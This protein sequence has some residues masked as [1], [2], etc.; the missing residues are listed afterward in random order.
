MSHLMSADENN[1]T[2]TRPPTG[3][4]LR[5]LLPYFR[6]HTASL[7]AAAL[8]VIIVT[9]VH[10]SRPLILRAIIDVAIPQSDMGY[11]I[12][13]ALLFVGCLAIG[14]AVRYGQV[15]VLAR[16]GARIIAGIKTE[17]FTHIVRHGMRFFD[18]HKVGTLLT[19]SESDVDQLKALFTNSTAQVF[20]SLI[21]LF[22]V[23]G[24]VVY[25]Q[26]WFG[27]WVA[28]AVPP[29][30]VALYYYMGYIRGLYRQIREK[31]SEI[32]G[33]IAEYIQGVPLIQLYN[34]EA[35]VRDRLVEYNRAKYA[36]ER[37]TMIIDYVLFWPTFN[38]IT[39]TLVVIGVFWYGSNQIAAGKMS[40]G[41]LVMFIELLR[42][43]F[44]PIREL[45]MVIAQIQTSLAASGRIFEILDTPTDVIDS[46]AEA[47][48]PR[49][50]RELT[51]DN[52]SFSYNKDVVLHD[53][54][55]AAKR[56]Q[57]VAIVGA[58]GSGK[59]TCV[60]LL[61][62]FYDPT[63][64]AVR[65]DGEDIRSYRLEDWRSRLALVLQEVYLF[66]GTIMDNLK[67]FSPEISDATVIA[68]AEAIGAHEF[69]M[70]RPQG[71]Q[72]EL[73]E[74]GANLS[75]GERQLLSYTR[76]MVRNPDLLIL[77]EATSA[78][79]VITERALQQSMQLLMRG[80]TAIII[81]HRLSTIRNADLILVFAD[82][83]IVESGTHAE[84]IDRPEGVYQ[85]LSAIQAIS[86]ERAAADVSAVLGAG[87]AP[88]GSR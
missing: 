87:V 76:A 71:Y 36:F 74:R 45:M 7:A 49:L 52:V 4:L 28:F 84:L 16:M 19:R 77:D 78:V 67:A 31:N 38:F 11:A 65:L 46:V 81:A 25:E 40:V 33:Y 17:L 15:L 72:T 12:R 88:T 6:P 35:A 44:G 26:P 51:F 48:E 64:G 50:Q 82:G 79:D 70:A 68:A 13:A 41:T 60:N 43:F 59:T 22:G 75:Q 57:H 62:R 3:S 8:A 39:E 47:R 66:P 10:L 9:A 53:V 73:A 63:S 27:I 58:S 21:M 69:I 30:S 83:R 80:R 29:A 23:V 20:S 14:A 37:K 55:F 61:L 86:E 34:R 85:K 54:S 32:T 5:R 56:G 1:G 2:T 24:I 18:R 42:Q